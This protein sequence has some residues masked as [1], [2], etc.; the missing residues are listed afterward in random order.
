MNAPTWT[1]GDYAL[2]NNLVGF[3]GHTTL[4]VRIEKV[5]SDRDILVR[6]ADLLNAGCLLNLNTSQLQAIETEHTL[7]HTTGLVTLG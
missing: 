2:A 7:R 1:P 5:L 4:R 3:G 6:T